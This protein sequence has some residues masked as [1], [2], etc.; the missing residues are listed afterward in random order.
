MLE[1]KRTKSVLSWARRHITGLS[2]YGKMR[3]PALKR[4]AF[5]NLPLVEGGTYY[6]LLE[7]KIF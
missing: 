7:R 2:A 5:K 3:E 4:F 1:C 6:L